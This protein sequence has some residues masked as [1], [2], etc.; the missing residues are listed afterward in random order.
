MAIKV[1]WPDI[2][3]LLQQG[4]GPTLEF[5][6]SVKTSKDLTK[7][8]VG[9]A[10]AQG[11]IIVAGIDD[12]N[13]HLTGVDQ[14]KDWAVNICK[15]ECEPAVT[16]QAGE[17]LRNQK[18]I[19]VLQVKEGVNKPYRTVDGSVLTREGSQTRQASVEEQKQLN[20]W[21]VGG[22]NP[23]QKKAL[24]FIS[25]NTS[26][27]NRQYREICDVSHKTAHIELTELVEKGLL[28]VEGQ[29][30][31]TA[32]ILSRKDGGTTPS[33]QETGTSAGQ[34]EQSLPSNGQLFTFEE[35]ND[36]S[37]KIELSKVV[38]TK[39]K[40]A[41]TMDKTAKSRPMGKEAAKVFDGDTIIEDDKATF[42]DEEEIAD[43]IDNELD[44]DGSYDTEPG[45]E[46]VMKRMTSSSA[47]NS[48]SAGD[49]D[50]TK[51]SFLEL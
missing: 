4:E 27:S 32:Y 6:P 26:I 3:K 46:K 39:P 23:R 43:V 40:P 34:S 15:T 48:S 33:V 31:S 30:R 35:A 51:P 22:I 41:K 28:T 16:V 29:G 1:S 17:L 44:E 8:V 14:D 25:D 49:N 37:E 11:G 21:G 12:K 24:Q 7:V 13:G 18:R 19:L 45:P 10:N 36:S 9:F 50:V 20:P 42:D 2:V 38:K 5:I 47:K